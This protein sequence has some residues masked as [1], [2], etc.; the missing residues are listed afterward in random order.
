MPMVLTVGFAA[1]AALLA[2]LGLLGVFGYW[3]SQRGKELGIRS[4]LGARAG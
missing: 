3:V 4:A 1:L 2:S